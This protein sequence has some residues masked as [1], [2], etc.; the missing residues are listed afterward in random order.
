MRTTVFTK[1]AVTLDLFN[2]QTFVHRCWLARL[3]ITE[4]MRFVGILVNSVTSPP[5]ENEHQFRDNPYMNGT[6]KKKKKQIIKATRRKKK[7]SLKGLFQIL[8]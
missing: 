6:W 1:L 2:V 3:C 5:G 4:Y 8:I 7:N